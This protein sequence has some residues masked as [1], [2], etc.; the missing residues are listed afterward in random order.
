M[1]VLDEHLSRL[2]EAFR[3]HFERRLAAASFGPRKWSLPKPRICVM[4]AKRSR[5]VLGWHSPKRWSRGSTNLDEIVLTPASVSGGVYHAADVLAHELVHMANAVA[6]RN[7][8]SRQGRYHND[9]FRETAKAVG[10]TVSQY[11]PHGWSD[12]KLGPS[13][14]ALVR[15][16]IERGDVSPH[17]FSYRRQTSRSGSSLVKMLA[18]C[19]VFAYVTRSQAGSAH[20]LCGECGS[21]LYPVA[22]RQRVR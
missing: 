6:D 20:L 3:Q 13:L 2:G 22:A 11:P 17:A 15:D 19:G 1:D 7:D 10:L 5:T 12:T 4:E 8:T 9:V 21:R 18:E 14:K 16:L